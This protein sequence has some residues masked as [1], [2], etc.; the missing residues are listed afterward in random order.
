LLKQKGKG[1]KHPHIEVD[2]TR[3]NPAIL[4]VRPLGNASPRG[5]E[6]CI[7]WDRTQ[8]GG[9]PSSWEGVRFIRAGKETG[10]SNYGTRTDSFHK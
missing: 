5:L 8:V 9:C 10:I 4:N 6:P 7:I 2:V 1:K 3:V